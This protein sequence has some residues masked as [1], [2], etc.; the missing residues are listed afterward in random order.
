MPSIDLPHGT[1]RYRVAGPENAAAPPVVFVHGFLVSS[2][3]WTETADALAA[4]GVR[5]YAADWPLGSHTIALGVGADQSPRGIARQVLAFMQALELD[6]V[7][8]VGNDT[9]GAIC[10][11]L[12]DLDASRVGR[13]V[14]TN[15]DAFTNFPPAP[16][17]LLFKGFRSP[18][19]IG[20]LM[21]PM[22]ATAVRHSPAGYGLLVNQPLDASQTRAWVDPC[23]NDPA[24]RQDVARFAQQVD[25]DDLDAASK[26][27]GNFDGPALLVWGAADRFFKLDFAR[28]LQSAFTNARL[29]E[30]EHGRSFIPHDEPKR[31]AAEIA[32]FVSA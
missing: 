32:A 23:L 21:A 5:S 11:F 24:I 14:L 31:L 17:D 18:K 27:L 8:L 7:T 28:R 1:V 29:V 20:A 15:C 12:L 3:L 26:R 4:D 6:D 10:Q 25:P 13:V 19:A 9:G 16:F 30:I 22:R 2:T